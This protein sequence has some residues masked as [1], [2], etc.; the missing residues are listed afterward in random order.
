MLDNLLNRPSVEAWKNEID[1]ILN[2]MRD[3]DI[4]MQGTFG[5]YIENIIE[6][7]R[8]KQYA[9]DC[10]DIAF[11][12]RFFSNA[13]S[14][15]TIEEIRFC[16]SVCSHFLYFNNIEIIIQ[17]INKESILYHKDIIFRNETLKSFCLYVLEA[18]NTATF[19]SPDSLVTEKIIQ[20]SNRIFGTDDSITSLVVFLQLVLIGNTIDLERLNTDSRRRTINYILKYPKLIYLE[21]A[22]KYINKAFTNFIS[23]FTNAMAENSCKLSTMGNSIIF[24][25]TELFL[26]PSHDEWLNL[27]KATGQAGNNS[28]DRVKELMKQINEN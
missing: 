6:S 5:A 12:D 11:K 19:F 4:E 24:P 1:Q 10:F 2:G 17:F 25:D 3:L 21:A 15:L 22:K 27:I 14:L 16:I 8:K 20:I 9:K 13:Q 28:K 18:I 26:E 23:E 7:S